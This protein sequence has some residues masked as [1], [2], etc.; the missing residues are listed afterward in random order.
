[1]TIQEY[2]EKKGITYK[3]LAKLVGCSQATITSIV[4]HKTAVKKE[5]VIQNLEALG[6]D[7]KEYDPFDRR[8]YEKG[9]SY[10]F[11]VQEKTLICCEKQGEIW[12]LSLKRLNQITQYLNRRRISYYVRPVE[13]DYWLVKYDKTIEEEEWLQ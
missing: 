9:E 13:Q 8:G 7:V 5:S 4:K 1:M 3:E 10:D 6:I 12:C 11:M 2:V